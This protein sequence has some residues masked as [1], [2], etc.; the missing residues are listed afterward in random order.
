MSSSHL[1]GET[2]EPHLARNVAGVIVDEEYYEH[3]Q[4]RVACP[5]VYLPCV[6]G[7]V[8]KGEQNL[9][10]LSICKVACLVTR[11]ARSRP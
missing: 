3:E 4:I 5:K 7:G 11:S 1:S 9:P 6:Q 10:I 8:D 2:C